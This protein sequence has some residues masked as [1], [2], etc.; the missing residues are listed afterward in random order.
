[1]NKS[2]RSVFIF[3]LYLALLGVILLVAPNFLLVMFFLPNTTEVWIRVVGVVVLFLA[4]YYIQ[5]ARSG[6]TD[7]F[8]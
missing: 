4:F 3:G 1:M 8:R 7:F 6:M 2:A 5:A